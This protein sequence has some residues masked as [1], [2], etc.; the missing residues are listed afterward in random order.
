[1]IFRFLGSKILFTHYFWGADSKSSVRFWRQFFS[2]NG[3]LE[4][5]FFSS[6]FTVT[7]NG[8]TICGS[9][10]QLCFPFLND[11]F[12]GDILLL[13]KLLKNNMYAFC[14]GLRAYN[15]CSFLHPFCMPINWCNKGQNFS[16]TPI[17]LL[18]SIQV[19]FLPQKRNTIF[20]LDICMLL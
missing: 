11:I 10:L 3:V 8:L 15:L 17:C 14:L 5:A 7:Y 12:K 2:K 9:S 16:Q 6:L 4:Q 18:F 19:T 13:K 1:M 20:F